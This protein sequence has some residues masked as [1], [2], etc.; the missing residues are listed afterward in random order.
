LQR[1]F[2]T[3]ITVHDSPFGSTSMFA[4]YAVMQYAKSM[5]MTVVLDGQG[6]DEVFAGYDVYQ[7]TRQYALLMSGQLGASLEANRLSPKPGTSKWL[8]AIAH[9]LH[10]RMYRQQ[11]DRIYA[12]TRQPSWQML[13]PRAR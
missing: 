7:S 8:K 13:G 6:A 2:D 3:M 4:Q 11:M 10:T 9:G 5:G 12:W 1:E